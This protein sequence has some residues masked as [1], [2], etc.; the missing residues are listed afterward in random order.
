MRARTAP[1]LARHTI[2]IGTG[3]TQTVPRMDLN[4]AI[5]TDVTNQND[6]FY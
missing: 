3:V 4:V 6:I 1:V 2:G 5:G